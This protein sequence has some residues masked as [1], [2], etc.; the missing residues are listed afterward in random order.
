MAQQ[1]QSGHGAS[2][3]FTIQSGG[4]DA[5][6][7]ILSGYSAISITPPAT[8]CE[9]VEFP[10]LGMAANTVVPKSAAGGIDGGEVSATIS[11]DPTD[12]WATHIG[13]LGSCVINYPAP[14]G[15][16]ASSHSFDAVLTSHTPGSLESGERMTA[17]IVLARTGDTT[18]T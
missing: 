4:D 12:D 11:V 7:N 8:T 14:S 2:V 10:H 5:G 15:G 3:T 6:S 13:D 9:M 18:I 1:N 16:S 17:E